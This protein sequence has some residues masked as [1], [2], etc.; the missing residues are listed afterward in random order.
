[1]ETKPLALIIED[2]IDQNLV[3][4]TALERAGYHTESIMDGL[5]AQKRLGEVVPRTIILDLHIP[6]VEGMVL[7]SQIRSDRRLVKSRVI[8]ATADAG[9]ADEL[10]AEVDLV[11]LKPISFLQLSHLARRFI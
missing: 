8:L 9:L 11:L 10:Q 6:E 4:T 3:F 5:T 1:M 7:L 2:D